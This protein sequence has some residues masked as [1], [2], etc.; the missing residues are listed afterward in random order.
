MSPSS[1]NPRLRRQTHQDA[2]TMTESH[3]LYLEKR[4][5]HKH[6]YN[7]R[8]RT[9]YP[10]YPNVVI[11]AKE[12]A[13]CFIT[14]SDDQADSSGLRQSQHGNDAVPTTVLSMNVKVA[15]GKRHVMVQ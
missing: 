15:L 3:P 8:V 12:K 6:N 4:E 10:T 14:M 1:Y 2:A 11:I 5:D 13:Y 7:L 9:S